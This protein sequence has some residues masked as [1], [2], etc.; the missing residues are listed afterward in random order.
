MKLL[1]QNPI[2]MLLGNFASFS[3]R[4]VSCFCQLLS[5]FTRDNQK[6]LVVA[7]YSRMKSRNGQDLVKIQ[8]VIPD[9]LKS[10]L[11]VCCYCTQ[12]EKFT[13]Q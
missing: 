8:S 10:R 9:I 2:K 13:K 5:C 6:S 7:I 4:I 12:P 3:G 11:L 1:I